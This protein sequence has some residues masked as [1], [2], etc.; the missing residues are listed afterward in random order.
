MIMQFD[1]HVHYMYYS[2]FPWLVRSIS[3]LDLPGST[4][5]L[6]MP[7]GGVVG[8]RRKG[9]RLTSTRNLQVNEQG[10]AIYIS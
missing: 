7:S 9:S 1:K 8:F 4:G 3:N 10:Q 2:S 6:S 5:A